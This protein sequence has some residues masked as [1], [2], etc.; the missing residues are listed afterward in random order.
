VL[1]R[2]I[3]R[4]TE[5]SCLC[6]IRYSRNF[7][8]RNGA[9]AAVST[10][11]GLPDASIVDERVHVLKEVKTWAHGSGLAFK[12]RNE[13]RQPTLLLRIQRL[14]TRRRTSDRQ[15]VCSWTLT[16][17]RAPEKQTVE[18]A[19]RRHSLAVGGG[20]GEIWRRHLR[21]PRVEEDRANDEETTTSE[22]AVG[23][24]IEEGDRGEA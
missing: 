20:D 10:A 4:A 21:L 19:P 14:A 1:S 7:T 22:D 11:R 2:G 13:A 18:A 17:G 23:F 24:E 6:P 16:S 15:L 5:L 12:R 3:T 9:K 8:T